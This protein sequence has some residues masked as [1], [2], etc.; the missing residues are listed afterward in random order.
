M[1]PMLFFDREGTLRLTSVP[2]R[3]SRPTTCATRQKSCPL[4]KIRSHKSL[5]WLFPERLVPTWLSLIF[6]RISGYWRGRRG[7][8]AEIFQIGFAE[9]YMYEAATRPTANG[10]VFRGL[11]VIGFAAINYINANVTPG[12]LSN[13]SAVYPHCRA[14]VVQILQI[15]KARASNV[16]AS[17]GTLIAPPSIA[18]E[19]V[20]DL[21]YANPRRLPVRSALRSVD[22][23][24]GPPRGALNWKSEETMTGCT[25]GVTDNHWSNHGRGQLRERTERTEINALPGSARQICVINVP[26]WPTAPARHAERS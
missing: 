15:R 9:A 24:S 8:S 4:S 22:R 23:Q 3:S 2:R 21:A 10:N 17:D 13:Y 7:C 1:S 18:F 25:I 6:C 14:R 26:D 20:A 19:A 11:P 12:V 5:T 16:V